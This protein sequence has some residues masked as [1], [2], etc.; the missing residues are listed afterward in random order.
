MK[1]I[2]KT[3]YLP[4]LNGLR[5]IAALSVLFEHVLQTGIADFGLRSVRN[6][7]IAGYGVT[8]FF[9]ISGFLI[10][11]LLI[12]ELDKTKTIDVKKFYFRRI[13]RIWPIYYLYMLVC[14]LILYFFFNDHS[15]FVGEIW[16][17]VFFTANI[18][19]VFHQGIMILVHYWSISVEEQFYLFWP[20]IV[21]FTKGE[22][23]KTTI[24]IFL[25]IVALKTLAWVNFGSESN[26]YRFLTVTR[27]H[28]MMLGAIG[29]FLYMNNYKLIINILTS[30]LVQIAS[31]SFFLLMGLGF[32]H[33]PA[34]VSQEIISFIALNLILSQILNVNNII[35]L[36]N[37]FFDFIGKISYGIYVIHP[38]IVLLLSRLY[39]FRLNE[40]DNLKYVVVYISVI[41]LTIL[42]AWISYNF[43]EKP[44][45]KLKTKFT[46]VKSTNSMM[47]KN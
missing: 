12:K 47:N 27:I 23:L 22:I 5:A 6:F 9:V 43:Y 14:S 7:P 10:T 18:P 20:W 46:I 26:L 21:R 19:F 17:Y 35:N 30:Y 24:F 45:L 28:C 42:L 4:G 8:F 1:E 25:F 39:K 36:E 15:F 2:E 44:F 29:A 33:V 11:F 34:V 37:A 13:L 3:V 16:Y 31:W 41:G 38:L 32:I 40:Y